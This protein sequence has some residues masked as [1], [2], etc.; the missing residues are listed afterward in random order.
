MHLAGIGAPCGR[1][2]ARLLQMNGLTMKATVTTPDIAERPAVRRAPP[3]LDA[4][5]GA[6]ER[7]SSPMD[8]HTILRLQSGA[9]NVAVA[10]LIAQRATARKARC[11]VAAP[12]P[13]S[14]MAAKNAARSAGTPQVYNAEMLGP[15]D[16]TG[17]GVQRLD[18][19]GSCPM[20]PVVPAAP[21]PYADPTFSAVTGHVTG[22]ATELKKHP[23]DKAAGNARAVTPHTDTVGRG[24]LFASRAFGWPGVESRRCRYRDRL[25]W[26]RKAA[27]RWRSSGRAFGTRLLRL[28]QMAVRI[29]HP[30]APTSPDDTRHQQPRPSPPGETSLSH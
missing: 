28:P 23:T 3:R 18:G 30:T 20:P 11:V 24:A 17:L 10:R 1:R 8:A 7:S 15:D 27:E 16:G 4:D 19:G 9:G 25:T 14:T 12:T 2:V 29:Q 21:D 13:A 5:F 6:W 22:G 26:G